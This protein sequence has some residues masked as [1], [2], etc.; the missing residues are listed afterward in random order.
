MV[1]Q[2]EHFPQRNDFNYMHALIEG[3]QQLI[4]DAINNKL[5]LRGE[6]PLR[7]RNDNGCNT[8]SL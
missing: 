2:N 5:E 7:S 4:I 8:S 6:G 3:D 1:L